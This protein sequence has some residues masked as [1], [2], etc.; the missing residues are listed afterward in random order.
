MVALEHS[1]AL[2]WSQRRAPVGTERRG[3]HCDRAAVRSVKSSRSVSDPVAR[4]KTAQR[5]VERLERELEQAR[6]AY[7][8]AIQ[9]AREAGMSLAQIGNELGVSRQR[10][11]QLLDKLHRPE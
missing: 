7:L 8:Q 5:R 11:R 1:L 3:P 6:R 9:K 10:V 2:A 4:I